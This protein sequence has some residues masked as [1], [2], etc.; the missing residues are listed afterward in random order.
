V[1]PYGQ[2]AF[3]TTAVGA[4]PTLVA[5]NSAGGTA[6]FRMDVCATYFS[7]CSATAPGTQQTA[8][9]PVADALR[10]YVGAGECGAMLRAAPARADRAR[11][12]AA[13]RRPA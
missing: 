3:F 10:V 13:R 11:C 4:N 9:A 2:I 7:N 1:A 12:V 5:L 6:I 8:A